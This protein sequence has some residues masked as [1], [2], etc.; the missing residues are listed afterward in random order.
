MIQLHIPI[1]FN[2]INMVNINVNTYVNTMSD[3]GQVTIRIGC[4]LMLIASLI[5]KYKYIYISNP[6]V[7]C[8]VIN[9]PHFSWAQ[10]PRTTADAAAE[11]CIAGVSK[12]GWGLACRFCRSGDAL[13]GHEWWGSWPLQVV[14]VEFELFLLRYSWFHVVSNIFSIIYGMS[15][16]PLT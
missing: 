8:Q 15:S 6:S 12:P 11:R 3:V 13:R 14:Q 1:L 5:Y 7:F 10:D 9:P 16:F 4:I 2:Q